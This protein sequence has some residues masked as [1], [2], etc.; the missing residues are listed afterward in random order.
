M[1]TYRLV[2]SLPSDVAKNIVTEYPN[3]VKSPAYRKRIEDYV[4]A[5]HGACWLRRPEIAAIVLDSWRHFDA[6]RY[7]L[8][9]WVIMPNH[10]HLVVQTIEPND[11][12]AAVNGW[13]SFSARRIND[14]LRRRGGLWQREYWD[15]FIR[16]EE[17]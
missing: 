1:L 8:H 16:N 7:R 12:A 13:K 3:G 11:L 14:L 5:G 6:V 15:R 9:A 10:V 2:D 4:D 17:H